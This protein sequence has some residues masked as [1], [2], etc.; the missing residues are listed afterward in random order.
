[1]EL[2][3]LYSKEMTNF[4]LLKKRLIKVRSLVNAN[5]ICGKI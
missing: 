2:F 1:M 3:E 5:E 4:F